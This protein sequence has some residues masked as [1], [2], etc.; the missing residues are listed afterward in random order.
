MVHGSA[1]ICR[2]C[3]PICRKT[4]A[5]T[6]FAGDGAQP[7]NITLTS[8]TEPDKNLGNLR[9][10][11]F[12]SKDRK[13]EF[14]FY[15]LTWSEITAKQKEVLAYDNS[16]NIPFAGEMNDLLKKFSNDTGPIR[17]SIWREQGGY[18][19]ILR[20]VILLDGQKRLGKLAGRCQAGVFL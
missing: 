17:L 12:L 20:P 13:R 6:G 3:H 7:K 10:N 14:L 4:V 11:R 15:E 18:F 1:T 2:I 8:R 5:R 9:I 19:G 16:E